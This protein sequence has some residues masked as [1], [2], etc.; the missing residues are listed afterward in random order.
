VR[1][2]NV[3]HRREADARAIHF[4]AYSL[5]FERARTQTAD[6]NEIKG[7]KA[8]KSADGMDDGTPSANT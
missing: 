6:F 4:T 1:I 8:E 3:F 2:D 7:L 5:D